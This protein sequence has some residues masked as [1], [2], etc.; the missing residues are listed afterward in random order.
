MV[1]EQIALVYR[2]GILSRFVW[3]LPVYK[4]ARSNPNLAAQALRVSA[5]GRKQSK[6]P[7]LPWK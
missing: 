4:P 3:H 6:A 2:P 7:S 1:D 5:F